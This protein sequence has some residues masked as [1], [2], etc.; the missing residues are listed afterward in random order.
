M[1]IT[2]LVLR[3]AA[4]LPDIEKN[5]RFLFIGPH[6]DDIEIGAGATAAKLA[7]MG[8]SVCFLICTDGRYGSETVP[9]EELIEIRKAECIAS[10]KALGVTDVRFL[11]LCDSGFY[12]EAELIEGIAGAVGDFKPDTVFAPDPCVTGECH[13]DHLNV[14][15]AARRIACFAPYPGLM[16][17]YCA[18]VSDVKALA[19]YFTAKANRCVSTRGFVNAQ[20]DAVFSCHKSQ[21]PEN[22]A[23]GSSISLYLKL[24]S[25][26]Y[27][28][29]SFSGRAEAFRVLGKT[30]MHCFPEGGD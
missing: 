26:S 29:R 25:I 20:L 27:G 18:D 7:A 13:D 10:A 1:S 16:E 12:S 8:K 6:P 11:G 2:R 21:F 24:R 22:G 15:R 14:G 23:E 4:P 30:H 3:A 9:P 19:F 17:R 5:S 28:I